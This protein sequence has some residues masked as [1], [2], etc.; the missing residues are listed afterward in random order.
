MY[1]MWFTPINH[2]YYL[3]YGNIYIFEHHDH[4]YCHFKIGA[5]CCLPRGLSIRTG[6][7][8]NSPGLSRPPNIAD[9]R[10]VVRVGTTRATR[11]TRH[12]GG[13]SERQQIVSCTQCG[14]S[15]CV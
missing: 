11:H 14:M 12:R 1:Y 8:P 7:Y 2:T 9:M 3:A 15:T 4:T 6:D 5:V 13:D 10:G